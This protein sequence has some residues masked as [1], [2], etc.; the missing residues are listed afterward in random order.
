MEGVREGEEAL[1]EGWRKGRKGNVW[2]MLY[3]GSSLQ[4]LTL[5]QVSLLSQDSLQAP[6]HDLRVVVTTIM[7][8][9]KFTIDIPSIYKKENGSPVLTQKTIVW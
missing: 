5:S 7:A 2:F 6:I 9:K 1:R 4:V 3:P 8:L